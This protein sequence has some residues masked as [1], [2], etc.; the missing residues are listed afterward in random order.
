MTLPIDSRNVSI[1]IA[2]LARDH[3]DKKSQAIA[4]LA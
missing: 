3:G 4:G 1:K 2:G